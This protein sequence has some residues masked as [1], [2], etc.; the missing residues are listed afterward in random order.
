MKPVFNKLHRPEPCSLS[1]QQAASLY[2]LGGSP[3]ATTILAEATRL[4]SNNSR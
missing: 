4:G 3:E 2:N 1:H